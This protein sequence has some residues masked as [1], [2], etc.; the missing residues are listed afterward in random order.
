MYKIDDIGSTYVSLPPN[1]QHTENQCFAYAF[2]RQIRR[3]AALARS[4]TMWSD[5]DH[6]DPKFYDYMALCI[7][8]PYYK[9][10]YDDQKKLELIKTA[11]ESRR[12][13][14]SERAINRLIHTIFEN[15]T[16]IPWHKYGGTPYQFRV[17]VYDI[18]T[19]DA[20]TMFTDI[21][22]KVKSA[23]SALGEIEIARKASGEAK[24]GVY[25]RSTC[26]GATIKQEE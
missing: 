11:I 5:L 24:I 8:A 17:K 4:L 26:K 12:Y 18:L 19:E 1:M 14:G 20:V 2:D 7:K 22:R 9:S 13:A 21:L 15:A 10:E 6:V 25:T 16:F 3:L 23:R